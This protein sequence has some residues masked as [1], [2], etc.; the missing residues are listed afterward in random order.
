V[1]LLKNDE[2]VDFYRLDH[3]PST[4]QTDRQTDVIRRQYRSIAIAW[5]GKKDSG[6]MRHRSQARE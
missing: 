2:V 1:I 4:L 6:N 5:S 3:N